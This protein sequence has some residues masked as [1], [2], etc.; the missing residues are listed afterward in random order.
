MRIAC[1]QV[2]TPTG[3]YTKAQRMKR[4]EEG[5]ADRERASARAAEEGVVAT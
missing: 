5:K 2:S 3:K 1:T 4:M